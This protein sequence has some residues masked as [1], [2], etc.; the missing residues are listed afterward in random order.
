MSQMVGPASKCHLRLTIAIQ[1]FVRTWC[2]V[3]HNEEW[4]FVVGDVIQ[5]LTDTPNVKDY[6]RKMRD[7]DGGNLERVGTNCHTPMRH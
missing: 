6:I 4:W 2:V 1:V 7:R 5:I 3:S